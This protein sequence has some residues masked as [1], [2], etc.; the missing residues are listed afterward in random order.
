MRRG[1]IM[2]LLAVGLTLT[3]LVTCGFAQK[4]KEVRDLQDQPFKMEGSGNHTLR[5]RALAASKRSTA[6]GLA[7]SCSIRT[8]S[9][10]ITGGALD[11]H[12]ELPGPVHL[13]GSEKGH[14]LFR[15]IVITPA[16]K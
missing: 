3:M 14:V 12:E 13:Q 1:V 10:C 6:S 4:D 5:A 2:R 8:G 9:C 7:N 16:T 11:S 15:S